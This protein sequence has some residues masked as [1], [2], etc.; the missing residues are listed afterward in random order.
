MFESKKRLKQIEE[1]KQQLEATR[2]QLEKM[3]Q[4]IEIEKQ[5]LIFIKE[6]LEDSTPKV[7]IS[8]LYIWKDKGISSIV[9]LEVEKIDGQ[10]YRGRNVSG[11]QSTLIDIFTGKIVYQKNS[12]RMM[13]KKEVMLG[14]N[15]T[16][17]YYSYFY[18]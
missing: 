18:P 7:D 11:Y 13:E 10:N 2:Q 9:R 12:T 4:Q 6:Q 3:K 15:L 14:N 1:E 5:E 8:D 17:T 16:N